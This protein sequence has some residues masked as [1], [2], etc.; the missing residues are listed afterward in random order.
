MSIS[1]RRFLQALGLGAVATAVPN[2]TDYEWN[3]EAWVP[4]RRV[5]AGVSVTH[6]QAEHVF[7]YLKYQ[8][9]ISAAFEP[10][11]LGMFTRDSDEP[12]YG[13]A[14]SWDANRAALVDEVELIRGGTSLGKV[15]IADLTYE[16]VPSLAILPADI[17]YLDKIGFHL[18]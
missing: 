6:K 3:G 7:A 12:V 4:R 10:F 11:D 2:L 5:F 15:S 16:R 13:T 17:V 18:D 1:R 8:G 14:I 9:N